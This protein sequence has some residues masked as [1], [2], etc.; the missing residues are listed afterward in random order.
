[1]MQSRRVLPL[2]SCIFRQT[3][4][5]QN[6][7]LQYRQLSAAVGSVT[8]AES[9][10]KYSGNDRTQIL[11]SR[12]RP[13]YYR[14]DTVG[15]S[16]KCLLLSAEEG[17]KLT[18]SQ[19][20]RASKL[21][22]L[23]R[24]EMRTLAKCFSAISMYKVQDPGLMD[25]LNV[26]KGRLALLSE[27]GQ[28]YSYYLIMCTCRGLG[29][30][31][32]QSAE[33][34]EIL[35][36]L[37]DQ[38]WMSKATWP[39]TEVAQMVYGLRLMSSHT[40]EVRSML[41]AINFAL[42]TCQ[43]PF[44]RKEMT[45]IL[46]GIHG[47]SSNH[48]EVREFLI[49]FTER[50]AL[51]TDPLPTT[52][53]FGLNNLSSDSQEVRSLLIILKDRVS[54]CMEP[55]NDSQAMNAMKGLSNMKSNVKEVKDLLAVLS[56]KIAQSS[57]PWSS[58]KIGRGMD[59]LKNMNSDEK[60]VRDLLVALKD[61]I[62]HCKEPFDSR[63]MGSAMNGMQG[64]SSDHIEVRDMLA[65]LSKKIGSCKGPPQ[66]FNIGCAIHGMQGMTSEWAEV[67]DMLVILTEMVESCRRPLDVGV[68]L[69]G[70]RR[71]STTPEVLGLVKALTNNIDTNG[72]PFSASQVGSAML[73]MQRLNSNFYHVRNLLK[74]LKVKIS[75]CEEPLNDI[76]I[77]SAFTGLRKMSSE[78]PEVRNILLELGRLMKHSN[79]IKNDTISYALYGLNCMSS[80]AK[81]VQYVLMCL[82]NLIPECEVG[83]TS[84]EVARSLYGLKSMSCDV[85]EVRSLIS[86]ITPFIQ[87]CKT[88]M[89]GLDVSHALYGLQNMSNDE[90]EVR[91]LLAIL[92][93]KV[94]EVKD[95]ISIKQV[96]NI[97]Y[98]LLNMRIDESW[99]PVL[100]ALLT[101]LSLCDES[102]EFAVY[103]SVSQTLNIMN[104]IEFPLTKS[105]KEFGLYEGF[106]RQRKRIMSM[107]YRHPDCNV[108]TGTNDFEN[109]L[110]RLASEA[111]HEIP[112]V[113]LE[114]NVFID[115]FEADMIIRRD[116]RRTINL[117]LDGIH[118]KSA[119]NQRFAGYR[120]QVLQ[121][122]RDIHVVRWDIHEQV[123]DKKGDTEIIGMLQTVAGF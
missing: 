48:S 45:D 23:A 123:M 118:H 5:P 92:R 107:F 2:L 31:S 94:E 50:V 106:E 62:Q 12:Y 9:P 113:T 25:V 49:S 63:T 37:T 111:F 93:P 120:D 6:F 35:T 41:K 60:E 78:W 3:L 55:M 46:Y 95:S 33:V 74:K 75:S 11:A 97:L 57:S 26:L 83:F 51:S 52:P 61:R 64:M 29:N 8:G 100:N 101:E 79:K 102:K 43:E 21:L 68:V 32:C 88:P 84:K 82:R 13:S 54:S 40:Q 121:K 87:E 80:D 14:L 115:G 18:D 90:E 59:G 109:R 99:V 42:N 105:L 112:T 98:G 91:N 72:S 96:A 30:K 77:F 47:M 65:V 38:I 19:L 81:E 7:P 119:K 58:V 76:S 67:R 110:F 44:H 85:H 104:T 116:G 53:L 15:D 24:L 122:K 66:A 103:V 71:M 39:V 117:E 86:T 16:V 114:T 89:F 34:R 36:L 108:A 1:M 10:V 28:V 69:M 73:G 17:I 27:Q 56:E 4:T 70:L 20:L 22:S